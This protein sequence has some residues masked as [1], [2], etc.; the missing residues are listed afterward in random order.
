MYLWASRCKR[1]YADTFQVGLVRPELG[2]RTLFPCLVTVSNDVKETL[3]EKTH[4]R[5]EKLL[6]YRHQCVAFEAYL[7]DVSQR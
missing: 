1:S 3:K 2:R 7:Y 5:G 4:D 6:R